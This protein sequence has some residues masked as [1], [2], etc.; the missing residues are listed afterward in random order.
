MSH[1]AVMVVHKL[2]D[3]LDEIMMPWHE[4]EC[5]G[6]NQYLQE[7]DITEEILKEYEQYGEGKPFRSWVEDWTSATLSFDDNGMLIKAIRLTNPNAKWDWWTI[8]GRY[9]NRLITNNGT[10]TDSHIKSDINFEA[11]RKRNIANREDLVARILKDMIK[12]SEKGFDKNMLNDIIKEY[13]KANAVW[14]EL[15]EPRPRGIEYTTWI[16][17][18]YGEDVR[19]YSSVDIWNELA[20]VNSSIQEWIDAAPALSTWAI[21][22]NG[23]WIE[24]GNMGWW[25]VS[26][27]D[28]DDWPETFQKI[29]SEV[30]SDMIITIV[31]C[32]I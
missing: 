12:K 24:K 15:P 9:S 14:R 31:D 32:H 4:Y 18:N 5:T 22:Q 2:E 3:N 6:I 13:R 26:T 29:L 16:N 11:M 23:Q 28:K 25:G 21:V 1:F 27:G 19:L 30:S 7:V 10:S 8:G 17:N 20:D